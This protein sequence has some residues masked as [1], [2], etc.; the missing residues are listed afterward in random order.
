MPLAFPELRSRLEAGA[1][2]VGTFCEIPSPES[3]EILAQAGWDF[4]VVDGE[5]APITAARFAEFVRA[6]ASAA[7]PVVIRVPENNAAAI[8]HALDAGAAG[9]LVPQV[10]SAAAAAAA[11]RAA[12]FY[13]EGLRGF[14]PFVRSASFSAL[15]V[16]DMMQR[17]R[18]VLLA[19]Q[20]E[21]AA[22][23]ADLDHIVR[24]SG[25]DVLFI[26]PYD[27]AQ[28]LGV[29]AQL[30]HPE[31]LDAGRRLVR[32]AGAHGIAV[33]VYANTAEQVRLWWELG[34]RF[35]TYSVD[36][37]YLLDGARTARLEVARQ[38]SAPALWEN[39]S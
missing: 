8:Q 30:T 32:E 22:A 23:F 12:R 18:S 38:L 16:P 39:K 3:V 6:G 4:V 10:S 33:G 29:P 21:S 24:L 31:V 28:S 17:A 34:V 19:L 1:P 36:V 2:V 27:L 25:I 9:I 35:I 5:H 7:I 13:P 20:L 11:V 15:S 14:N 26:G 37:R